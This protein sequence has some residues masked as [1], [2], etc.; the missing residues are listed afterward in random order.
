[1]ESG[2]CACRVR[3]KVEPST[4]VGIASLRADGCRSVPL[5]PARIPRAQSPHLCFVSLRLAQT[6]FAVGG[7]ESG[8]DSFV[9]NHEGDVGLE[10]PWAMAI[11]L[12]P[13][14]PGSGA[15]G[16]ARCT[17]H[18]FHHGDDGDVGMVM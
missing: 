9:R 7:E 13:T 10:E 18:V 16:D 11:M 14:R 1:M 5:T 6:E 12:T 4:H 2:F 15:T 8:P 17:A 3:G